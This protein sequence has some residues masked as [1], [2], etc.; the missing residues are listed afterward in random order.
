MWVW[1][2]KN[3]KTLSHTASMIIIMTMMLAMTKGEI[4]QQQKHIQHTSHY[5]NQKHL[6]GGSDRVS[7]SG[8]D[9]EQWKSVLNNKTKHLLI[10]INHLG[11]TIIRQTNQQWLHTP[12][13]WLLIPTHQPPTNPYDEAT[14]RMSS[15]PQLVRCDPTSYSEWGSK[16]QRML[17]HHTFWSGTNE[18]TYI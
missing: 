5:R 15:C 13:I 2:F 9:K 17:D 10:I 6:S 7:V 14:K 1:D 18:C 4:K 3:V 8:N 11:R 12:T 16:L